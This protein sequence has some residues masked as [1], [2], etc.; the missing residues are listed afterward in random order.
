MS[1]SYLSSGPGSSDRS[2]VRLRVGDNSSG[3]QLL[4][5]EEIDLLLSEAGNKYAAG[6]AAARAIAAHYGRNVSKTIGKLR[7]EMSQASE[8]Y[9]SLAEDLD[10]EAASGAAASDGMNSPYA[11][12]VSLSDRASDAADTD[13]PDYAFTRGQFD[14][15]GTG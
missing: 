9:R 13:R 11:G 15:P 8:A 10:D 1:W 3:D 7:I 4:Q 5:N 14:N 2:W 12:G 6:A